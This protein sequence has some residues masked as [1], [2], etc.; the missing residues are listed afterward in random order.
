MR[1]WLRALAW[2]WLLASACT[3]DAAP[4]R[5]CSTD[6]DCPD[7]ACRDGVCI[8]FSTPL[9]EPV[10]PSATPDAGDASP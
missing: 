7:E 2:L 4:R 5:E 9:D 6:R 1:R 3:F 10:D 8:G